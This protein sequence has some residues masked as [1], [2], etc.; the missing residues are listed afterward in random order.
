VVALTVGELRWELQLA[1]QGPTLSEQLGERITRGGDVILSRAAFSQR[2]VYHDA[3]R[4]IADHDERLALR[5]VVDTDRP[6]ELEPLVRALANVRVY[7]SYNLWG[8]QANGSR[9]SGDLYLHPNG[10]NVFA[11]LRNW[12]DRRDLLPQ[13]D[14]VLNGLR[15]AFPDM[16]ADIDFRVAGLTVTVDL[17]DPNSHQSFPLAVAPDG[18]ITG[19]LQLTAVAGAPEGSVVAI[20]DF[21]NDL[22]PYAIRTLTEAFREWA[23]ERKLIVCLASHSP[24]LLDE[25]KEQPDAVFVMDQGRQDRPVPLTDL[26]DPDWLSRFS[27]GRL[28]EHGEFGGQRSK[29]GA[30]TDEEP[31]QAAT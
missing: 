19:L 28:Y 12:R 31:E 29:V 17:L 13:Y 26:F 22:H 24:V 3:E 27:L 8:L 9:Q 6:A 15:S 21:G 18:W 20:D 7:R 11:V 14:F 16:F 5:I 10:Q 23:D 2:F 4:Q 1:T 30:H 25:F